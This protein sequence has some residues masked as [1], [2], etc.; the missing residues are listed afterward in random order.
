MSENCT[1]NAGVVT[2]RIIDP[3]LE[4]VTIQLYVVAY[5]ETPR[6][7]WLEI[8]FMRASGGMPREVDDRLV[9]MHHIARHLHPPSAIK[10][11]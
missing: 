3:S 8:F 11:R 10:E 2:V 6:R 5:G 7:D 1:G 4:D 9:A